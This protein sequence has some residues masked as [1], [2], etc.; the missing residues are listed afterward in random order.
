MLGIGKY[1]KKNTNFPT[2]V[3]RRIFYSKNLY[4]LLTA[5]AATRDYHYIDRHVYGMNYFFN[6]VPEYKLIYVEVS[7]A[8]CSTVKSILSNVCYGRDFKDQFYLCH[9][10]EYSGLISPEMIGPERFCKMLRD[11]ETLMFTVVRNPYLR[12]QSCYS[13]KFAGVPWDAPDDHF[14]KQYRKNNQFTQP[15]TYVSDNAITFDQFIKYACATATKMVNNHWNL[16]SANVPK[17]VP[18]IH[19]AKLETLN[20]DIKPVADRLGIDAQ[21]FSPRKTAVNTT[22]SHAY[23]SLWTSDLVKR[24]QSAYREDFT[25]FNY[26]LEFPGTTTD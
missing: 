24:V 16:M 19:V 21:M 3:Q 9:R 4:N 26:P 6:V 12:L 10:R 5:D 15:D 18:S 7:K 17:S 20:E 1:I 13:D 2:F 22:G 25:R 14:M 8:G 23:G 11:P